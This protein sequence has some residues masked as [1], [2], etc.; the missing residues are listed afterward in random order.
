MRE[1]DDW[2]RVIKVK[3]WRRWPYLFNLHFIFEVGHAAKIEK[4][5]RMKETTRNPK[6]E[7]QGNNDNDINSI[8]TTLLP[9]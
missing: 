4:R 5:I 6:I 3:E 8:Y 9:F 2:E 7:S 1:I